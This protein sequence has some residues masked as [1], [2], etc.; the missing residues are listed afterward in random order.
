MALR[1]SHLATAIIVAFLSTQPAL[2][3]KPAHAG[4]GGGG[5][6][7]GQSQNHDRGNGNGK[8]D[9]AEKNAHGSR[10]ESPDRA[11]RSGKSSHQRQVDSQ[12]SGNRDRDYR[13]D[14]GDSLS[15]NIHF[16][17]QQRSYLREYYGEEFRAGR[18]PPGLAKKH[19]GCMPPGQAKKW[20]MGYPLDRDVIFYDLPPT[21]VARIGLPPSGYRY[22]RVASDILMIAIGTGLVVDAVAD[23]AN[24]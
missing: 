17:D 4:G 8:Q 20:R 22:V 5:Q 14:R 2:A 11:D 13:G 23:L 19:N 12:N 9:K 7:K 21:I 6:G 10:G 18:C 24:M 1:K 16:N 3:D 15:I